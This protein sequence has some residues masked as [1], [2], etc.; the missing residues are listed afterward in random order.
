MKNTTITIAE[1]ATEAEEFKI[2]LETRGYTVEYGIESMVDGSPCSDN[3][4][5]SDL[6]NRLWENYCNA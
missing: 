4:N 6:H 3:T 5:A 2:F 1:D